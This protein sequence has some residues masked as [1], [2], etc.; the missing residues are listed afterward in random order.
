[1][2]LLSTW[3]S[4]RNTPHESTSEKPSFLLFGRDC[5]YTV[6]AAF[7]PESELEDTD[8]TDY[9][10]ELA[11]VL[12]QARDVAASTIQTAQTRYK[13][14]YEK[15]KINNCVA[16][17]HRVGNRILIRFPQDKTGKLRMLSRP[18]HGPFRSIC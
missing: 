9:R 3:S 15:N 6:E 2:G 18:W 14:Q 13:R 16:G 1:M 7:L 11:S 5:R 12:T 4:Y 10:C 17:E 8:I